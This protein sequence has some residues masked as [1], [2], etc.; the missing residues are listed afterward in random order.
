[1]VGIAKE[2]T[3]RGLQSPYPFFP[4][5]SPHSLLSQGFVGFF[6]LLTASK[7]PLLTAKQ[8]IWTPTSVWALEY[9]YRIKQPA[10]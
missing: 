3:D 2:D 8:H 5:Y 9:L 4:D 7:Q 6:C 1:M 10:K